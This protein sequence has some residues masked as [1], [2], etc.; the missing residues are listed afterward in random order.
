MY[1]LGGSGIGVGLNCIRI[2]RHMNDAPSPTSLSQKCF[3]VRESESMSDGCE[4]QDTIW[5]MSSFGRSKKR[6]LAVSSLAESAMVGG[7]LED[8]VESEFFRFLAGGP[9][10]MVYR[11]RGW[12]QR[13]NR[14]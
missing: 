9:V 14:Q 3:E 11:R 8:K 7:S 4:S 5:S 10:A 12:K 2:R 13:I 1:R 6:H